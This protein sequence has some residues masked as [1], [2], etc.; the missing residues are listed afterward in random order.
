VVTLALLLPAP[1]APPKQLTACA[2]SLTIRVEWV[3]GKNVIWVNPDGSRV[4]Y[5]GG[6]SALHLPRPRPV[7]NRP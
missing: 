7:L 5:P 2:R 6:A 3:C 4:F 1:K